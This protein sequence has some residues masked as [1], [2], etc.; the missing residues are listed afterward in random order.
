M[1]YIFVSFREMIMS[2]DNVVQ[3][4]PQ[5]SCGILP[6]E[7]GCRPG[8]LSRNQLSLDIV[9]TTKSS[10]RYDY[11]MSLIL[12]PVSQRNVA[13]HFAASNVWRR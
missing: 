5:V 2:S 10:K 4:R 7:G 11:Y 12:H 8:R 9:V 3:R 1:E 13:I 6:S